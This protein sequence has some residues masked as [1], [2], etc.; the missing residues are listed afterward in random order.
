MQTA[1]GNGHLTKH[2]TTAGIIT[3][4]IFLI[5]WKYVYCDIL[6][7]LSLQNL[8]VELSSLMQWYMEVGLWG[9]N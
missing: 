2:M 4:R 9:S 7:V 3:F 8:H 6:N 5:L 1:Y